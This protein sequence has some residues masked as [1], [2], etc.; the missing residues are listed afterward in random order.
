MK[1]FDIEAGN[2]VLS[3]E[4]IAVPQFKAIWNRDKSKNKHKAYNELSYVIF[5]CDN[6]VANPYRQIADDDRSIMLKRDIFG[7]EEYKIDEK[8]E[9]AIETL[10]TMKET[11]S[12]RL[13]KSAKI[14]ADKL[15]DYFENKVNFDDLDIN[16]KPLYSAK[17]L[18]SNLGAVGKIIESLKK[19]EE[20]VVKE[21]ADGGLA[22]GGAEIGVFELPSEDI[23]YGEDSL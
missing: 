16:G 11:T 15:A 4:F 17:D 21:Q 14:A 23:D 6:T 7:N 1:A 10:T 12:S 3:P 2:V 20:Q 18:A 13:L 5:L 8:L 19:L 22:R 9:K